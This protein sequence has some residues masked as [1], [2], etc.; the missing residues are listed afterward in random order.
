MEAKTDSL[1]ELRILSGTLDD[2]E[3]RILNIFAGQGQEPLLCR[4][5]RRQRNDPAPYKALSYV[6]GDQTEQSS[7]S[8][9][10][11]E[12]QVGRNLS[13][14]ILT[15]RN[16]RIAT[17]L[18]VDAICINQ[19][20]DDERNRQ[21]RRMGDIY[22]GAEEVL[23]WLGR[24]GSPSSTLQDAWDLILNM[25]NLNA[26][27][28]RSKYHAYRAVFGHEWFGRLWVLQEAV[29]AQKATLHSWTGAMRPRSIP[30]E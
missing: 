15:L 7:M 3:T 4:L 18:W 21:V 10:D 12:C 17:H 24:S 27:E 14:A 11:I 19:D 8:I 23:I 20:D 22:V 1:S 6:W 2:D 26:E 16:L 29:L 25:K 30:A 28:R 5:E 9:N 13:E